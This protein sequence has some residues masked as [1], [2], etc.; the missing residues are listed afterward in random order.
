M[1]PFEIEY[2]RSSSGRNGAPTLVPVPDGKGSKVNA[3]IL[4]LKDEVSL[5]KAKDILYRREI[6]K[7]FDANK[8][9][10]DERQRSK[11]NRISVA[12]SL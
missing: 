2:A 1:T 10:D 12:R 4:V 3:K 6:H 9:Y 11:H 5:Q 7:V 8:I